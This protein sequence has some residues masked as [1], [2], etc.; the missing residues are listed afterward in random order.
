MTHSLLKKCL[1]TTNLK[2]TAYVPCNDVNYKNTTI[3]LSEY[4]VGNVKKKEGYD[5]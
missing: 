5:V 4:E 3:I 2:I 1:K